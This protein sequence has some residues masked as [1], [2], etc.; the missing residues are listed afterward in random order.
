MKQS[1]CLCLVVFAIAGCS[2]EK[3]VQP[4]QP[5]A[6]AASPQEATPTPKPAASRTPPVAQKAVKKTPSPWFWRQISRTNGW[7][8]DLNLAYLPNRNTVLAE[9]DSRKKKVRVTLRDAKKEPIKMILIDQ[10]HEG[11]RVARHG[12]LVYL[13]LY[14]LYSTGASVLALNDHDLSVKW[15]YTVEGLG[16]V[17]HS[18][19]FNEAQLS[20]RD[21]KLWVYGKESYGAYIEAINLDTGKLISNERISK[22]IISSVWPKTLKFPDTVLDQP[23][24]LPARTKGEDAMYK[25]VVSKKDPRRHDQGIFVSR[26]NATEDTQWYKMFGPA[27]M[28]QARMVECGG[29]LLVARYHRNASGL[30]LDALDAMTGQ[31]RWATGAFGVGPVSHSRYANQVA[32]GCDQA[33]GHFIIY[34]KESAA[35]YIERRDIKTGKLVA[36]TRIHQ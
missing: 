27:S 22:A 28:G 19:Y 9:Y 5:I 6:T 16:D 8:N 3:V 33:N 29:A 13:V 4:N 24:T 1:I 30:H 35:H 14:H 2:K 23:V 34:G 36:N 10:S 15:R 25:L 31:P 20:V 12:K 21:G 18:E 11:V 26:V 7:K 32:L 17:K